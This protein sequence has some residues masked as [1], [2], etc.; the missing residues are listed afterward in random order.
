MQYSA[1]MR[2]RG[3]CRTV[4]GNVLHRAWKCCPYCF[5]IRII[6]LSQSAFQFISWMDRTRSACH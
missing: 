5:T 1:S 3:L 6:T 4:P 2:W